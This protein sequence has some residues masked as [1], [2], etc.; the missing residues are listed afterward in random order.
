MTTGDAPGPVRSLA[1]ARAGEAVLIRRILFDALRTL[2]ADLGVLE[3]D[4]VS[5]RAGT[6]THL[7]LRTSAGRT[8]PLD[9]EWARFIQV[10]E[11]LPPSP[12]PRQTSEADAA[13]IV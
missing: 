6:A 13:M 4:V 9:R 8:I 7:V 12:P 3:G 1:A 5:C 10:G 11:P 2:C